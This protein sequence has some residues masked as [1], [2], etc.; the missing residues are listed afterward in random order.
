[1]TSKLKTCVTALFLSAVALDQALAFFK[2]TPADSGSAAGPVG[3]P[4]LDGPGGL[5]AIALLVSI[6]VV[7]FNRSRSA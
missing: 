6:A 5:A 7:L 1:M 3:T 4:E 2:V